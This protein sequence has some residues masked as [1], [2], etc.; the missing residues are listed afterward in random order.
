M[1]PFKCG[2]ISI[3]RNFYNWYWSRNPFHGWNLI[4]SRSFIFRLE[5]YPFL[6]FFLF[7]N[8][9]NSPQR[10]DCIY[11]PLSFPNRYFILG[12]T[13]IL[14]FFNFYPGGIYGVSSEQKEIL[15]SRTER[16]L[17]QVTILTFTE[18]IMVDFDIES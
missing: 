3:N 7:F 11:T 5:V 18:T 17:E 13:K 9:F 12:P 14:F 2:L 16:V 4:G 6:A 15:Q 8:F 1:L 10:G